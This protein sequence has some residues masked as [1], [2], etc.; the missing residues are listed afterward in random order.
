MLGGSLPGSTIENYYFLTVAILAIPTF[1]LIREML[2]IAKI[3]GTDQ[4]RVLWYFVAT[5]S[6]LF[7]ILLN[8]YAIGV[9]FAV[10]G[11]RKFLQGGYGWSGFLL[12]LSAAS[13]LVTAAPALGMVLAIRNRDDA[14]GFVASAVLCFAAINAP[15]I[16]L[17]PS[18]WLSFWQY[19]S[20]WYIE[21]SWMLAFLPS[22]SPLRH[23]VF[24]ILFVLLYGVIVWISRRTAIGS[25]ITLSWLTTFAFLFSTYVFTPQMQLILLPFFAVVPIVKRYWEFLAFDIINSLFLVLAFSEILLPFGITYS[26]DV[27]AYAD[28][29]RWLAILRSVWLGKML[30]LDGLLPPMPAKVRSWAQSLRLVGDPVGRPSPRPV[31]PTAVHESE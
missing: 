8:W 2:E 10:F 20:D 30:L 17:N 24:P 18:L 27:S 7:I 28:P 14:V 25:V 5:P 22:F 26:F 6:F 19:H 31:A 21:G 12:G 11:I 4:N 13:N 1:L 3:I 15:F 16:A 23:F 29:L 9:Y